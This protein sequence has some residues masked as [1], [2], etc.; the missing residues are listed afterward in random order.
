[1]KTINNFKKISVFFIFVLVV[2]CKPTKTLKSNTEIIGRSAYD[3]Y[4]AFGEYIW[5]RD[6]KGG[7]SINK[8]NLKKI[9]A[10]TKKGNIEYFEFLEG[11]TAHL[12]R[13]K[14]RVAKSLNF[15]EITFV[16]AY[17]VENLYKC[18]KVISLKSIN[19]LIVF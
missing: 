10:M 3:E 19:L 7:I 14:R 8:K 13:D 9:Y 11:Y 17:C 4:N 16:T 12:S 15:S 5:Y 18:Q 1:M 2:S 6:S